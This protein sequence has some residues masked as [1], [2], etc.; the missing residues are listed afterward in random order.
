[1]ASKTNRHCSDEALHETSINETE[2]L[3]PDTT[4]AM[5]KKRKLSTT[6]QKIEDKPTRKEWKTLG[7]EANASDD[8]TKSREVL[9]HQLEQVITQCLQT[10]NQRESSLKHYARLLEQ[11][12]LD[13]RAMKNELRRKVMAYEKMTGIALSE[14]RTRL[15]MEA[16]IQEDFSS[17]NVI[18]ETDRFSLDVVLMKDE[19]TGKPED[20]LC[21]RLDWPN[22]ESM[23]ATSQNGVISY[24]P[25]QNCHEY[26]PAV[27]HKCAKIHQNQLQAFMSDCLHHFHAAKKLNL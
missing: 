6:D 8:K 21:F 23:S 18:A 12:N 15:P 24:K 27:L 2:A 16:C 14:S 25:L 20:Q 17:S 22:T 9:R 26:L 19:S 5:A 3:L 1:M 10:A 13:L 11:E 4:P 7:D